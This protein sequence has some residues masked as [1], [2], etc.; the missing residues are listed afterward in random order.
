MRLLTLKAADMMWTSV[1]NKEASP[2]T[3][4]IKSSPLNTLRLDRAI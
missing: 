3:L 1:G 4:Q 2:E